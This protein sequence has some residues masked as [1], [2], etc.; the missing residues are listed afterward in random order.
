MKK[1]V[2]AAAVAAVLAVP[3]VAM[4]DVTVSG[5]LQAELRSVGGDGTNG[6]LP[7]GLYATDGGQ[8]GN[9]NGGNWGFLKF[10]ASEDLGNGLKALAMWD[11]AVNI[12]AANGGTNNGGMTGR[13]AYVGLAG[14]WG[15]GLAGTLS[16]PYK[17]STGGWDPVGTTSLQ[18]RGNGGLSA[19]QNG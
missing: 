9:Q 15:A 12:G 4:A 1:S 18:A 10:S 14:G 11:G 3:V 19:A 13:D 6:A 7:T 5:G 17:A 8:A 16:S 2:I